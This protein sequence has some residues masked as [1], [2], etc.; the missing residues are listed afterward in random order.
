M[1]AEGPAFICD[2]MRGHQST[3]RQLSEKGLALAELSEATFKSPRRPRPPSPAGTGTGRFKGQ[4]TP[5][6]EVTSILRE[7]PIRVNHFAT[8]DGYEV[9]VI[10]MKPG[11]GQM[12]D[13]ACMVRRF[14]AVVPPIDRLESNS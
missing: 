2:T 12:P 1:S 10:E 13:A 5:M 14:R 6:P 9:R 11:Y 7:K 3:E 4:I 8:T